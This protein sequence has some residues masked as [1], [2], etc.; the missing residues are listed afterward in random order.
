M[1]NLLPKKI[2]LL[3][4]GILIWQFLIL[5]IKSFALNYVP[6]EGEAFEGFTPTPGAT[7]AGQFLS[8]VFQFGLALAAAL[9]VIMIVWGGIQ[10]ML[11]DSVFN[12][13]EGKKK[14]W[15]AIWGLILAL[16]SW[17][18]LYTINPNILTF[19]I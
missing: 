12:K 6:L 5:P 14:I 7:S 8:Q 13:E 3:A 15:N 11:S 18:I 9:A 16:V 1:K 4:S 17:L 2:S 19:K 10:I